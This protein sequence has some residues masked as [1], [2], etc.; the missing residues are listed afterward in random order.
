VKLNTG[1]SSGHRFV[2]IVILG[3]L[4]MIA[5]W[6]GVLLHQYSLADK[7]L[8]ADYFS[9]NQ[10]KYG[11][12]SGNNWTYQV[13][14]IIAT[15]IDS[16]AL[17]SG[18]KAVLK[19]QIS[20]LLNRLFDE[21]DKVLHKER[22]GLKDKLRYGI[23]NTIVDVDHFRE[24]IPRFSNAIVEE[25]ERSKYKGQLKAMLKDKVTGILDAAN[26]DT[27][28]EKW[29]VIRK[30]N[31]KSIAEFN[32]F[33]TAETDAIRD[34][35]RLR[36]FGVAGILLLVLGLWIYI[37]KIRKFYALTFIFS[38]LISFIAL[39][40]GISLPMIE[41][42]ARITELNLTLLSSHIV[43]YDQVIFYQAKSIL[44]V[45]HIL[46]TNGRADTVFVG[47]LILLFSVL[48]PV[49]KL[50][51][52]T[53]FLFRKER[54]HKIIRFMAF[55]SGKWS[56]AD[57]MVIAIF[58]AYVGF[59]SILDDQLQDITAHSETI[60]VVTTNRTNL[61]T[62]FLVF[63]AFTLFNLILAEILK[64]ITSPKAAGNQE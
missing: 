18:N 33:I 62:G 47:F 22:K 38:V 61:Q 64:H 12:L 4:S 46:I 17:G 60:N 16:F 6:L 29:S 7:K 26:Q 43:F 50:V 14:N 35:Q 25:V 10:I 40:I 15:K 54:S 42:D 2:I 52:T 11:L 20:D 45:I 63:V 31:K 57:V 48:F 5:V 30:Y 36:G 21:A 1:N 44:D 56:M 32:A 58:M 49:T 41:I 8:K 28:G 19:K 23:I 39:F 59:Q 53:I 51:S 3:V 34:Q 13:N 9:V 37:T 24:E 27:L 55:K